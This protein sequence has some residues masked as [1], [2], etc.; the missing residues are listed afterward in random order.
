MVC[1]LLYKDDIYSQG[2][3]AF[4]SEKAQLS[5]WEIEKDNI[6]KE[7]RWKSHFFYDVPIF[8][9]R[10]QSLWPNLREAVK[11]YLADFFR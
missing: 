1:F 5:L 3:N 11:N 8:S 9:Q 4:E 10:G 6:L 2:F 7:K